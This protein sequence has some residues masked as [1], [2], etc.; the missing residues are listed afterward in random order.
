LD[1]DSLRELAEKLNR[2]PEELHGW[3]LENLRLHGILTK[4][5]GKFHR[6]YFLPSIGIF[7]LIRERTSPHTLNA[8]YLIKQPELKIEPQKRTRGLPKPA[9]ATQK[10]M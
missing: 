5:D 1:E 6:V 7:S 9:W 10:G 3:I 2:D 4:V 8:L